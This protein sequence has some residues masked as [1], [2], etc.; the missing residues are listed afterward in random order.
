MDL[1]LR[2][3]TFII[4]TFKS[5]KIIDGCLKSL[6]KESNKIV[7]EN[8]KNLNLKKELETKYDNIE[9]IISENNGMGASNNIGLK[10]CSTQFA[11]ILNPDVHLRDNSISKIIDAVKL[12]DDFSILSP[13]NDDSDYPN[14][15]IK[16]EYNN[17]NENIISVDHLDGFSLL[18]NLQNFKDQIFFDESFFLYLENDDLCLRTKKKNEKIYLIKDS[19][20]K[21]LGASSSKLD[22]S[23]ELEYSRNWHWMWSKFYYNKKHYGYLKALLSISSNFLSSILKF[24]FYFIVLNKEKKNIYKM[25]ISGIFNSI[26]GKNSWYRPKVDI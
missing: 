14:Y 5:D 20:I 10:K 16:N 3:I 25:R 23:K 21:H 18:I 8:S 24:I 19:I 7:I 11:Y 2:N 13:I 12:I 9:V 17:I 1:N 26:I 6:P 22:Q 15:L 4:V